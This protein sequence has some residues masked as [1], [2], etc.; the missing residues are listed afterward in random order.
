MTRPDCG[1]GATTS[2]PH[3]SD[4]MK[5]RGLMALP[6]LGPRVQSLLAAAFASF[7]GKFRGVCV[8]QVGPCRVRRFRMAHRSWRLS[9]VAVALGGFVLASC[10]P[11]PAPSGPPL[12]HRMAA[13]G[14]SIT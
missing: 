9:L 4:A 5:E 2:P 12:P 13:V 14:D 10:V 11:P 3:R 7:G 8:H 6:T 1:T